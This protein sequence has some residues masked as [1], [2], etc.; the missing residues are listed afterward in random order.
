MLIPLSTR[1]FMSDKQNKRFF[2]I[3]VDRKK[4]YVLFL[5]SGYIRERIMSNIN[6]LIGVSIDI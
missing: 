4:N 5:I 2:S 6:C 3:F 1:H